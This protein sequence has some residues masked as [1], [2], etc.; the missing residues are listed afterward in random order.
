MTSSLSFSLKILLLEDFSTET[1]LAVLHIHNE[2]FLLITIDYI[3]TNNVNITGSRVC[4]RARVRQVPQCLSAATLP[5]RVPNR[6]LPSHTVLMQ[7]A[8]VSIT[9]P[10]LTALL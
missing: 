6:A 5:G 2:T 10:R 1:S 4:A 7:Q 8:E 9:R 3:S